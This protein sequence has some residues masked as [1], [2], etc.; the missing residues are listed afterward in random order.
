MQ[1]IHEEDVGQALLLCIVGAG[2][3]GVYNIAGDGIVSAIDV[4]RA[5][6]AIPIPLPEAPTRTA[7]RVL[8]RL[9][10][11]PPAAEWVEALSH[12]SIM[13]TTRA[14]TELGWKPRYTGLEALQDTLH[15]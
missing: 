11:L 6:G 14:H 9:P 1:F 5:V 2:Q 12:P 10:L 13:D 8:A 4:A 7:A 3:P 15:R